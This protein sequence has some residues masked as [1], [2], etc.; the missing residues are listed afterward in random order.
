VR[1]REFIAGLGSA[2]VPGLWP[3][4]MHAQQLNRMRRIGVLMGHI[5]SDPEFQSRVAAFVEEFA[6]LGWVDGRNVQIDQRWGNADVDRVKAFAKE[7][8]ALQPDAIVAGGTPATTAL[9]Q[10]TRTIPIVF[11]VVYD[12]VGSALVD[13]L[14]RPRAN[15]TGFQ[16]MDGT[17]GGKLLQLIKEIAPSVRRAAAMYNPDVATFANFFVGSFEAA[18]QA[19]MVDPTIAQVRNDAEIEEAI[20]LLG[21][22]QGGLVLIPDNFFGS[23]RQAA[24]ITS[25]IRNKVPA[26]FVIERFVKDGGLMAYGPDILNSMRGAAGYVDRILKGEKPA[27][28]PVQ[29]PTKYDLT[30]NLKTARAL[31]LEVPPSILLSADEVIE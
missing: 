30:I 18:A 25:A 31:G 14:A 27:D 2:A 4:G 9:Q 11:S 7:L 21:R 28:L 24:V 26:I 6:R 29:L 19:L 17:I 15:L 23:H 3:L 12:P 5:E 22:E 8:V 13:G 16:L 1:R 20:D 10:E